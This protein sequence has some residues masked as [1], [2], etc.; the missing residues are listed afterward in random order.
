[1]SLI[2]LAQIALLAAGAT[3]SNLSIAAAASTTPGWGTTAIATATASS[4]ASAHVLEIMSLTS[5]PKAWTADAGNAYN[6][7]LP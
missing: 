1:M 7:A 4:S 6:C 5:S 3:R 2:R